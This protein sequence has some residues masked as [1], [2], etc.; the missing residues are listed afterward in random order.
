MQKCSKKTTNTRRRQKW[1][2]T[3]PVW[4]S[5][6][7]GGGGSRA[8]PDPHFVHVKKIQIFEGGGSRTSPIRDPDFILV[9]KNGQLWAVSGS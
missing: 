3:P 1:K 6:N 2:K 4:N 7:R 5:P 9:S 8:P